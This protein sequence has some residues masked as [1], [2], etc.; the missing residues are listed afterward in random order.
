MMK[1]GLFFG[2]ANT[3]SLVDL[4][5]GEILTHTSDHGTIQKWFQFYDGNYTLTL[6]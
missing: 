4:K 3:V 1:L 5:T 6:L 2:A